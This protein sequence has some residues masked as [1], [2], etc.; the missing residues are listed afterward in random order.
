MLGCAIDDTDFGGG[1][2]PRRNIEAVNTRL[3]T[4][5]LVKAILLSTLAGSLV[6]V[7][8][9]WLAADSSAALLVAA[10]VAAIA[11]NAVSHVRRIGI[12]SNR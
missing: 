12:P 7:V 8:T 2:S 3:I 6:Y 11:A 9:F 4:T 10:I 5:R 1:L